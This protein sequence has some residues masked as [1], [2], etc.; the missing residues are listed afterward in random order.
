MENKKVY[1]VFK[2]EWNYSYVFTI[3]SK[4]EDAEKFVEEYNKTVNYEEDKAHYVEYFIDNYVGVTTKDKCTA[5]IS[6][7]KSMKNYG[8]CYIEVKKVL[9]ETEESSVDT[10]GYCIFAYSFNSVN[11]AINLAKNKY[12]EITKEDIKEI[13]YR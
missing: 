4:Q 8:V 12:K 9:L 3:F 2:Y 10:N 7:D 6:I 1:L 5:Y 11:E 13:I